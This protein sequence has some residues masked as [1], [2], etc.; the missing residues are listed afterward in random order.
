MTPW[1]GMGPDLA[2]YL[3]TAA[4]TPPAAAVLEAMR[5]AQSQGWANP[6]SLHGFGLKAAEQLERSRSTVARCLDCPAEAVV[7]TSGGTEAIHLAILGATEA[8]QPGRLLISAVE[9]P[10]ATAAAERLRQ[11][12][13]EIAVVPVNG[14]GLIDLPVLESLLVPPTRMV[15]LIWGQNEV[16]SLQPIEA[17]GQ[18]CRRRQVL[19]HVDAVQVVGKV[20]LA[21]MPLP[22]DLLSCAAH[23]FMGPRGIGALLIR[24]GVPLV[25]QLGGGGQ[26]AGLRAG[27]EPVPLA[28]GMA[29][30]L[31]LAV[32]RFASAN[33]PLGPLEQL[34][35]ALL[36]RLLQLPGV[37]LCG[38]PPGPQRLPHHISLM[39]RGANEAPLPG[40][41]VVRRLAAQ[42][43]AVSSGSACSST[44][45]GASP[46]LEAMGFG[47]EVAASGLRISLGPWHGPGLLDTVPAALAAAMAA[48]GIG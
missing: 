11:R 5:N 35:N 21:F 16:G 27:T 25:S 36:E 29:Q 18:L 28:V 41:A 44:G 26:E 15:S 17:V 33:E 7:F 24:P 39:L 13:W 30:A 47:P 43:L 20:P 40:R 9:H 46:V 31:E 37:R 32:E 3:D 34:R 8:L 23:K 2:N 6:S 38:P 48:E 19:L 14:E 12:G 10:A 42:G 45:R 22:V 4:T 1:Q